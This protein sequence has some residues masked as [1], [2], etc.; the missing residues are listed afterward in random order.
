MS[1]RSNGSYIG[2]N[3]VTTTSQ[4]SASGIDVVSIDV[5]DTAGLGDGDPVVG[6]LDEVHLVTSFYLSGREHAEQ[7]SGEPGVLREHRKVFASVP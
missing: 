4:D 6:A 3:R 2:Y 1:L 5:D 7:V